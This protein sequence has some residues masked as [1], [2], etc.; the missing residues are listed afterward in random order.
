[1]DDTPSNASLAL[2]EKAGGVQVNSGNV[3][4]QVI[5]KSLT[6]PAAVAK[7]CNAS[8]LILVIC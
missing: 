8:L 1:M 7:V 2:W 4:T 6:T 5:Q 3:I